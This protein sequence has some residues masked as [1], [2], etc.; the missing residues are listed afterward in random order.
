MQ[1]LKTLHFDLSFLSIFCLMISSWIRDHTVPLGRVSKSF[2]GI[3]TQL[4]GKLNLIMS[5]W[6]VCA[7]AHADKNRE[8][9]EKERNSRLGRKIRYF[10]PKVAWL[11]PSPNYNSGHTFRAQRVL[12]QNHKGIFE[13]VWV[14]V[15]LIILMYYWDSER[16][17][18]SHAF[19]RCLRS[20]LS[21]KLLALDMMRSWEV[22]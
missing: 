19:R 18:S 8:R 17:V 22:F 21:K 15:I 6:S 2:S 4:P 16:S 20:L 1:A 7:S 3:H 9:S 13:I 10:P 14:S 12:C 11:A 5:P